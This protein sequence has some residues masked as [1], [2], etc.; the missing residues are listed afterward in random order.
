MVKYFKSILKDKNQKRA[1]NNIMN[2]IEQKNSLWDFKGF[3]D[4]LRGLLKIDLNKSAKRTK[5]IANAMNFSG[6]N[7]TAKKT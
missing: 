6:K 4:S 5:V 1:D 3:S 7:I 2:I